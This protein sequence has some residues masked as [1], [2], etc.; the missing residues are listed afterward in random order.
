MGNLPWAH[1]SFLLQA[2]A[3]AT[4]EP[5]LMWVTTRCWQRAGHALGP[6][7]CFVLWRERVWFSASQ[8]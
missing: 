4:E 7:F 2:S 1:T 8:F 6:Q 5:V 3:G